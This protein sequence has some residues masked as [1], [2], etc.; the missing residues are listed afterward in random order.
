MIKT[1][2]ISETAHNLLYSYKNHSD[3]FDKAIKRLILQSSIGDFFKISFIRQNEGQV[4]I[5]GKLQ[6]ID[7][8]FLIL[9]NGSKSFAIEFSGAQIEKIDSFP[10]LQSE[11]DEEASKPFIPLGN[12]DKN[13]NFIRKEVTY[14]AIRRD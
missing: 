2:K 10:L 7:D 6:S 11:N 13:G 9:T 8:N 3:S 5:K 4:S 12:F 14:E 1:L